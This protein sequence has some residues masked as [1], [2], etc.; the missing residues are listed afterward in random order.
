MVNYLQTRI[1]YKIQGP[2]GA[3]KLYILFAWNNNK[4]TAW[5]HEVMFV[6]DDNDVAVVACCSII[7]IDIIHSYESIIT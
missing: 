5:D 7:N 3:L 2:K 4:Y 1:K 6:S